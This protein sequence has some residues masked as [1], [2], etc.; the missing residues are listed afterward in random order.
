MRKANMPPH[1]WFLDELELREVMGWTSE[2]L[3]A[4]RYRECPDLEV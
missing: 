2:E 4:I 1:A 3:A